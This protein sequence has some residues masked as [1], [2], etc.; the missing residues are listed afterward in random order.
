MYSSSHRQQPEL[1]VY[2]EISSLPPSSEKLDDEWSQFHPCEIR[3]QIQRKDPLSMLANA[4][5]M[6]RY[7]YEVDESR[8]SSRYRISYVK[9]GLSV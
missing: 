9:Y 2:Q 4:S 6:Q 7:E 1:K 5:S 3:Q 8:L